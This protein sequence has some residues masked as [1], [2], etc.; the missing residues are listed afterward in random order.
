MTD[1]CPSC[2]RRGI[3][4]VVSRGRGET[5]VHGY[6]CPACGHA[7]ITARHLPAYTTTRRSAA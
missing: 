1:S 4:P 5:V 3:P 7:W 6:H 2:C